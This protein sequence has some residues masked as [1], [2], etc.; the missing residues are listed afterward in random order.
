MNFIVEVE[1]SISRI[2]DYN[3]YKYWY[4]RKAFTRVRNWSFMDYVIFILA[5]KGR[6]SV[7]EIE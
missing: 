2:E 6:S 3:D 4:G 1:N 5:N 7:I